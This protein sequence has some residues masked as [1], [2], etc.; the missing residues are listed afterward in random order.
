[1]EHQVKPK[2]KYASNIDGNGGAMAQ[3]LSSSYMT[4]IVLSMCIMSFKLNE[5]GT[6]VVPTWDLQSE[7]L[8]SAQE[9]VELQPSGSE[10]RIY[11]PVG[12]KSDKQRMEI[13]IANEHIKIWPSLLVIRRMSIST[14]MKDN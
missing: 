9:E 11:S 3:L 6:A 1:M 13:Q 14:T 10:V 4:N 8:S 7:K 5:A 12:L 2:S